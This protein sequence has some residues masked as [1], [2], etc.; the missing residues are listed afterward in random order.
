MTRWPVCYPASSLTADIRNQSRRS[1]LLNLEVG[2]RIV[3]PLRAATTPRFGTAQDKASFPG[4]GQTLL[5]ENV[6][7]GDR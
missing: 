1:F 3:P 5:A 2:L 7:S 6:G 4:E